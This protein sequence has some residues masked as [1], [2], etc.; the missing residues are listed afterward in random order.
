MIVKPI[1]NINQLIED[2]EK[3]FHRKRKREVAPS[4]RT[5]GSSRAIGPLLFSFLVKSLDGCS[6]WW[7][8]LKTVQLKFCSGISTLFSNFIDL[9]LLFW[10]ACSWWIDFEEDCWNVGAVK[11]NEFCGWWRLLLMLKEPMGEKRLDK[12]T[13]RWRKLLEKRK[14]SPGQICQSRFS[15]ELCPMVSLS[16]FAVKTCLFCWG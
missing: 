13:I 2:G 9:Y 3:I 5:L 15:C 4:D 14:D 7:S 12:V 16:E 10:R 1:G 8:S 11:I 6:I